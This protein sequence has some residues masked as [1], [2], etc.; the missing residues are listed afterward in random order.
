MLNKPPS[1]LLASLLVLGPWTPFVVALL[2]S[3]FVPL[4]QSV[5]VLIADHEAA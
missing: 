3:A 1:S 5:D 4:A 2:D